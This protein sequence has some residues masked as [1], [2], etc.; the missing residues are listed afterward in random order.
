MLYQYAD[1]K[2]LSEASITLKRL[3]GLELDGPEECVKNFKTTFKPTEGSVKDF[4]T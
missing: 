4:K 2:K 1:C 3:N